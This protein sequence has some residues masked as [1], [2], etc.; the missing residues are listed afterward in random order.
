MSKVA[1]NG[2]IVDQ[3][4]AVV[5]IF[6]HGF[7]YGM[8]IFETI[9]LKNGKPL[10]WDKHMRRMKGSLESYGIEFQLDEQQWLSVIQHLSLLNNHEDG[11]VKIQVT[12]GAESSLYVE[13]YTNPHWFI[14]TRS[15]PKMFPEW[16]A[17]VVPIE[18]TTPE[19]NVRVKSHQYANNILAKRAVGNK[20]GVEGL[21]L[22]PIGNV[23]E[24][25]TS[26]VFFVKQ[27]KVFTP[28]LESGCLPGI[29]RSNVLEYMRD[30]GIEVE[31]KNFLLEE[32]HQATEMFFTNAVQ[33]IMPVK[34]LD[35]LGTFAGVKGSITSA[36]QKMCD[37]R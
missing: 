28:P 4:K 3:A 34:H 12:A 35:A 1:F 30:L 20:E 22:D 27:N 14:I 19:T 13:R 25:I 2:D 36:L 15:K 18:R 6:D 17:V 29:M 32:M 31:E 16:E 11:V 8:G 26:N 33:G 10:S 24:G 7:A 37:N 9:R 23:V 5:S 21:F